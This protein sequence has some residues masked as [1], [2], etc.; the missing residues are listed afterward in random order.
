[1][2][3]REGARGSRSPLDQPGRR[4]KRGSSLTSWATSVL[5]PFSPLQGSELL[6]ANG[7]KVRAASITL[8]PIFLRDFARNITEITGL[9][10]LTFSWSKAWG[11]HHDPP[12]FT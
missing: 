8:A 3:V 9:V 5:P 12:A 6:A 1:M 7:G 10:A 11:Y 4:V 2:V